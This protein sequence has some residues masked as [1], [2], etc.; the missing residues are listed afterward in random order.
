VSRKEG[1]IG[2]RRGPSLQVV[3]R[4]AALAAILAATLLPISAHAE[5]AAEKT[6]PAAAKDAPQENAGPEATSTNNAESSPPVVAPEPGTPAGEAQIP[7]TEEETPLITEETGNIAEAPAETGTAGES[8]LITEGPSVEATPE[9]TDTPLVNGAEAESPGAFIPD[10]GT[11]PE[12]LPPFIPSAPADEQPPPLDVP[13]SPPNAA[14]SRPVAGASNVAEPPEPPFMLPAPSEVAGPVEGYTAPTISLQ[15]PALAPLPDR[16]PDDA[17]VRPQRSYLEQRPL[18][19]LDEEETDEELAARNIEESLKQ[20]DLALETRP[21]EP[22]RI[23]LPS[24]ELTFKAADAFE[25]DRR[26]RVLKFTGNAEI[27]MADIGIWADLIELDDGAA[28]AYARG[29]V[30]VQQKDEILFCDEAYINYDTKTLELFWVEGNTAGN[31]MQGR[32]YF[33]A[34]RAYGSFDHL[35]MERVKATTCDPYCG[36]VDEYHISA[37]KAIYKRDSSIVLHDAHIYIRSHKVGWIPFLAFPLTRQLRDLQEESDIRQTYG[38]NNADGYFAK[39]AYTYSTR[40]VDGVNSPLLGVVKLD[41]TEKQG[42]GFGIRQDFY[43]GALGITTIR[44][45]Y[46]REWPWEVASGS[47]PQ[48]NLDFYLYQELNFSRAL[49]GKIEVD[50]TNKAIA[51]PSTTAQEGVKRTNTWNNNFS[52]NYKEGDTSSSITASQGINVSGGY[53]RPDGTQEPRVE[54]ITSNAD[55]KFNQ[56]ISDELKF[57]LSEHYTS[58][59]GGSGRQDLAAD[60]EGDF[61][62]ELNWTG[63]RDTDAEGWQS[64]MAYREHGIDYDREKYTLDRNVT[65]RKE[66]PSLQISSPRDFFGDNAFFTGF[67]LNIDELVTGRRSELENMRRRLEKLEQQLA[68]ETDPEEREEIIAEMK[69]IKLDVQR[70]KFKISGAHRFRFS[71]ASG[72]QTNLGFEQNWYDDGNA[73]YV[74]TPRLSYNYD[75]K[76]W[77]KFDAGWNMTY[78]RGVREPPVTGDRRTYNQ[79]ANWTFTFTNRR[80]WRWI[81]RSSYDIKN[82]RLNPI[83]SSFSWD[84]N[85]TFGLTQTMRWNLDVGVPSDKENRL[86]AEG[87]DIN[88]LMRQAG[89]PVDDLTAEELTAEKEVYLKSKRFKLQPTSLTG[90]VRSPYVDP[91]GYYNWYLRFALDNDP[92]KAW[93]T[94]RFSLTY[95]RR[96]K[97]GWSAEI[98]GYYR[99]KGALYV[100]DEDG[101]DTDRYADVFSHFRRQVLVSDFIKKIAV[102]KVSCCTTIEAGWRTGINEFYVNLYLNALPQYPGTMDS[103][104]MFDENALAVVD[105]YFPGQAV[106]YDI[107]QDMF[108]INRNDI[109]NF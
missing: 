7:A 2:L 22:I 63:A 50:R 9:T 80:S 48:E 81:L 17:F 97:R 20:L 65:I 54:T 96:Y 105:L 53:T 87:Y 24:G 92:A 35:I 68:E 102:R 1:G 74:L 45:Y 13:T 85:R 42:P 69:T 64:R 28:T 76:T 86:I 39:F 104:R 38:Y 23:P 62:I 82:D 91:Q 83:S 75:P 3:T 6:S 57:S 72:L 103:T 16:P 67:T 59:K 26:N 30:A 78:P 12:P 34:D 5:N 71:N 89:I 25:F 21:D 70:I 100:K 98:T 79:S 47:E 107:L 33:E 4:L 56:E 77:W 31:R 18:P 49:S 88:Q 51:V 8:P 40:Y 94:S 14:E 11:T 99:S 60:Q 27:M 66:R 90:F 58:R 37:R 55:F 61:D 19:P 52:L 95:Y 43:T 15:V 101:N 41:I 106:A 46:Q 36:T 73:L 29:Y 84:P 44:A 93:Q 109:P 10:E 32:L 108:G